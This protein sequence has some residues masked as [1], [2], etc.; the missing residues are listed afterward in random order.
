MQA[1][2]AEREHEEDDAV[3]GRAD[4]GRDG[5]PRTIVDAPAQGRADE[6]VDGLRDDEGRAAGGDD[7]PRRPDGLVERL[8]GR[9]GCEWTR[10]AM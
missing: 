2:G 8:P 4:A 7:P 5:D 3:D 9:P 1:G 10:S 6:V